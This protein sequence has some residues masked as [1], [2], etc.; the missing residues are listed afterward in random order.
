MGM[1][2]VCWVS[3]TKNSI[4][5]LTRGGPVAARFVLEQQVLKK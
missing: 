1:L 3:K 2:F 4:F 5:P